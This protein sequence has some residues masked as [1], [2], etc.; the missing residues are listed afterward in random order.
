MSE[1]TR[2]QCFFFNAFQ[3]IS[4]YS[5]LWEQIRPGV[6]KFSM[7]QKSL[8]WLAKTQMLSNTE[9]LIQYFWNRVQEFAY[10]KISQVILIILFYNNIL[11]MTGLDSW[12]S[13]YRPETSNI[14]IISVLISN[15]ESLVHSISTN[16]NLHFG[17][18][19]WLF[20]YTLSLWLN[21]LRHC[22][23]FWFSRFHHGAWDS[24]LL[25]STQEMSVLLVCKSHFVCVCVSCLVM[26]DS[27]QPRRL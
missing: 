14:S 9:F 18:I 20:F 21:G 13:K 11:G 3:M 24:A 26:S 22:F 15:V 4:M 17:E 10:L 8:K 2:H 27:L 19:L 5:Q 25:I 16:R 6:L 23:L 12:Y 7:C 1:G